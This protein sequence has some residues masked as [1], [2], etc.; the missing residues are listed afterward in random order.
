MW[1]PLPLSS[2]S[3]YAQAAVAAGVLVR[4]ALLQMLPWQ[5]VQQVRVV[6]SRAVVALAQATAAAAVARQGGCLASA[7]PINLG[8]PCQG[9]HS[10]STVAIASQIAQA[11]A[12]WAAAAPK[13]TLLVVRAV[14]LVLA[15]VAAVCWVGCRALQA[16]IGPKE[17]LQLGRGG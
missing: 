7:A 1:T 10:A 17:P 5:R 12:S 8:V 6:S 16:L 15:V 13:A 9:L 4:R 11:A 3:R 14:Q 2:S